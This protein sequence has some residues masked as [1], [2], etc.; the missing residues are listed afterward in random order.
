MTELEFTLQG[1][2]FPVCGI[3]ARQ[4]CKTLDHDP[5]KMQWGVQS[6]VA[7]SELRLFVSAVLGEAIEVSNENVEGLSALCREFQCGS[8]LQRL[9]AFTITPMY[10]IARLEQRFSK[11]EKD[12]QTVQNDVKTLTGRVDATTS[13]SGDVIGTLAQ[14]RRAVYTLK[15]YTGALPSLIVSDF[16]VIFAEFFGKRF[17][18]LWRGSR[19]GFR[20]RD[21]H[22]RCD[23][24]ANTLTVILDTDGNIFGGFTP[25]E[26][27]SRSRTKADQNAKSFLFTLKNPHN[28]PARRFPLYA[29]ERNNAIWCG[30]GCGPHFSDIGIQDNCNANAFN[31]TR[32]FGKNY[33]NDTGLNG[34]T[35]F[36]SSENFQVREIEVF[37]IAV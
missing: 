23:G 17:A 8:L 3:V 6:P 16:P 1:R 12:V 32:D 9:E 11:L 2:R 5:Q 35:F 30:S 26:W 13:T 4:A 27:D 15:E 31:Y 19:D 34:S 22:R 10:R 36:T 21:F 7:D 14:I 37:E 33:N 18:L 29:R 28:V 25:V 20:V 24:H